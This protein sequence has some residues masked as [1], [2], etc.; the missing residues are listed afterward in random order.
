MEMIS[1]TLLNSISVIYLFQNPHLILAPYT[2]L[3]SL[4]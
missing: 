4:F 2:K 1:P 3:V